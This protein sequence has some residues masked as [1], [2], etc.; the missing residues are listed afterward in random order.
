[1]SRLRIVRP[2]AWV[3][4]GLLSLLFARGAMADPV[5][6][7]AGPVAQPGTSEL[8]DPSLVG[9]VLADVSTTWWSAVDPMYG[10]PGAQG[11]LEARV[12]R[13]SGTGTL[14]FYWRITVDGVSYP[15]DVPL[16]LTISGLPLS[17]FPGGVAFDA[18]YRTDG[19]GDVAPVDASATAQSVTWDFAPGSLGP[20][21]STHFLL[22]RSIAGGFDAS[23]L[24]DYGA[25]SAITFAPTPIPEPPALAMA[26]AGL[27]LL[28]AGF[29]QARRRF[30]GGARK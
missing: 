24:A 15:N 6:P 5:A 20:A 2:L 26:A 8:A 29:G 22:L 19:P 17:R 30:E 18:D 25:I 1:M 3:A 4:A 12:V 9:T 14:D 23:A 10:F 7:G 13:E 16:L 11:E 28:A 21:S 27:A